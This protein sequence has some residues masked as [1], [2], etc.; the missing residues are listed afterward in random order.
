[1]KD[2]L[3]VKFIIAFFVLFVCFVIFYLIP[4]EYER[5]TR[6]ET[7]AEEGCIALGHPRDLNTVY[8]Y[9]CGGEIRMKRVK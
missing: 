7:I 5:S 8:F 4:R 6:A 3:F 1:M 9:D 2:D